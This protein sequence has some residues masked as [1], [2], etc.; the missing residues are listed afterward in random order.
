MLNYDQEN[1]RYLLTATAQEL[2]QQSHRL[3]ADYHRKFPLKPGLSKEELRRQLPPAME[4]R[5]FNYLLGGMAQKKQVVSEKDLVRLSTHKVTLAQDQEDVSRRLEDLYRRSLFSPPTFKEATEASKIAG[6]K[7]K[8]LLRVLVNQGRL[9]KVKEDLYF[10][11][12]AIEQ[13]KA[14]LIDFLKQNREITV[15]QFKDLTQTSRKF[16]IPLLEY[17][18]SV[19]TTVR[20]GEA[21]RL[22]E[23]A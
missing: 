21:R 5:L 6:D 4:V 3:L 23:G 16:T 9:V 15:N 18:D 11:Q 1:Q 2:E 22:R 14:T 7:V 8:Q 10:H 20:V 13:L 12:A 17:F 19:R